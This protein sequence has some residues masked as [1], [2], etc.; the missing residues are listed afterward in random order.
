[1]SSPS[2]EEIRRVMQYMVGQQGYVER[3][4]GAAR[5]SFLRWLRVTGFGWM[6]G[7]LFDLA[8]SGIKKL[9]GF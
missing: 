1:M 2:P 6:V 5:H 8:W 3:S 7:K 4:Q 9:F